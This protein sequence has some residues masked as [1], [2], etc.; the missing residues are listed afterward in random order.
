MNTA[1]LCVLTILVLFA[2]WGA[3]RGA[4][5]QLLT[6][7]AIGTGLFLATRYGSVL[8]STVGKIAGV[9]GEV[10]GAT[11]WFALFIAT[12]VVAAVLCSF[13][14][15]WLAQRE[16]SGAARRSLGA[17]LGLLTGIAVLVVVGYGVLGYDHGPSDRPALQHETGTSPSEASRTGD[18]AWVRSARASTAAGLLTKGGDRVLHRDWLPGWMRGWMER[19]ESDVR[20]DRP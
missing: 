20:N 15:G 8:E 7:V 16:V 2:V 4:A 3:L 14:R 10:R 12:L 1:D 18:P 9:D 19:V 6:L 5:R 11:A 13:L 17:A